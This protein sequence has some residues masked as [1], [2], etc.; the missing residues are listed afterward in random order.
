MSRRRDRDHALLLFG[1]RL[2]NVLNGMRVG[3]AL[4]R[5]PTLRDA[6]LTAALRVGIDVD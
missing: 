4:V 2:A 6:V 3:G 1:D 5:N